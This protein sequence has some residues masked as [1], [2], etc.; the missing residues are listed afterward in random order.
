MTERHGQDSLQLNAL[1]ATLDQAVLFVNAQQHILRCTRGALGWL[2][3]EGLTGQALSG[4]FPADMARA[5]GVAMDRA[6]TESKPQTLL[7]ELQPE[8]LPAWRPLGLRQAR[9]VELRVAAAAPGWLL[10]MREQDAAQ[11][12]RGSSRTQRDSLAAVSP[13]AELRLSLPRAR[14]AATSAPAA[15]GA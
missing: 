9:T 6:Q 3:P 14:R 13:R 5:I 11:S 1:L 8:R 10:V 4:L 15:A 12:E 2:Q 7:L